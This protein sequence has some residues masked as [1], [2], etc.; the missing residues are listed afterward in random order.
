MKGKLALKK[1]RVSIPPAFQSC[2]PYFLSGM[3]VVVVAVSSK[4][5]KLRWLERGLVSRKMSD[6]K[7]ETPVL[8]KSLFALSSSVN[9]S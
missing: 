3:E 2:V 6:T 8:P 4:V 7:I 1:T 5:R 9:I